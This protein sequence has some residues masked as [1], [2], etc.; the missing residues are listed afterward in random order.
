MVDVFA[1]A[2]AWLDANR[3]FVSAVVLD[4][5]G[6]TPQVTGARALI[7]ASGEIWGT[8]GGG[9]AEAEAQ[10][11]AAEVCRANRPIVLDI[12]MRHDYTRDG[13]AIC[14]GH[15]RILLSPADAEDRSIYAT[16][17]EARRRRERGALVTTI[18]AF[19]ETRID[20]QWVPESGAGNAPVFP[21]VE[22]VRA[23]LAQESA[24]L[25]A[26]DAAAPEDRIVALVEPIVPHPILLIAGGGHIGQ[27][28][29]QLGSTLGFE[30]TVI[31]DRAEFCAAERFPKGV[32]TRCGDIAIETAA[33]RI[34]RDVFI[35]LVTRGHKQDAEALEA[36]IHS[37]AAYIGMIGSTRKVTMLR[38]SFLESGLAT[39]AEFD[40]VYAPIGLDIGAVTVPEIAVSIAA[41]LVAVRRTGRAER[42]PRVQA[43]P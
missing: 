25:F 5:D 32:T 36:C 27:S 30:V 35:V 1:K 4:T 16:I 10:R 26:N 22:S 11:H 8:L 20:V 7:D 2:I 41:Q 3:R 12:D 31:D 21:G 24:R 40:R 28:L 34:T 43:V 14:G 19:P 13:G 29:A 37:P 23:T 42:M 17:A 15:M 38:K 18:R 6:S 39:E 9:F 33:F